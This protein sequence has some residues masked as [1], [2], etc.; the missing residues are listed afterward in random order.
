MGTNLLVETDVL[1]DMKG[2]LIK[3]VLTKIVLTIMLR[4]SNI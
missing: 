2:K 3:K 4:E 1:F